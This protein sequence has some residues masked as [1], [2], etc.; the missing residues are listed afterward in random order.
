MPGHTVRVTQYLSVAV[1][2]HA[3]LHGHSSFGPEPAAVRVVSVGV[4]RVER[5]GGVGVAALRVGRITGALLP[6]LDGLGPPVYEPEALVTEARVPLEPC[7]TGGRGLDL[8]SFQLHET[9]RSLT[10][11]GSVG[12]LQ[13][14]ISCVGKKVC[15]YKLKKFALL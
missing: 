13:S 10:Q 9:S 8:R 1:S 15:F 12:F 14:R 4:V 5:S 3:L 11:L 7:E 6:V 2:G